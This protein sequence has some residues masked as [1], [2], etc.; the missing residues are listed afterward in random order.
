MIGAAFG[1][2][3][4][5]HCVCLQ[6][7]PVVI[8][9]ES[10]VGYFIR[11]GV[12][13]ARGSANACQAQSVEGVV[14]YLVRSFFEK[15][16]VFA[17]VV[18]ASVLTGSL[19]QTLAG[20]AQN[21][22]P[23][24]LFD[25]SVGFRAELVDMRF[26]ESVE[27]SERSIAVTDE[28]IDEYRMVIATI[29]IEKPADTELTL[30]CADITLHYYHGGTPDVSPCLGM[31]NFST[32]LET[33]REL[34]VRPA[35]SGPGFLKKTTLARASE[36]ATVFVDAI[37]GS[38]ESDTREAW[39]AIGQTDAV[40]PYISEGWLADDTTP[41]AVTSAIAVNSS[42][43]GTWSSTCQSANRS[44]RYAGYFTFSLNA[45][46]SVEITLESSED[47][48]LY[49]LR[50]SKPSRVV[51]DSDDDGGGGT[52]S[53][54]SADLEAGDYTIEATTY[55]EDTTGSFTVQLN[56]TPR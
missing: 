2:H 6:R 4:R 51:I 56:S 46:A 37:F 12:A 49:L 43:S 42:A 33:D 30:P 38:M 36:A 17:A 26:A 14:R 9:G 11:S 18:A 27:G 25:R 55:S 16:R 22:A 23:A 45:P 47:T 5:R 3:S 19:G 34:E 44:S 32:V 8:F 40:A 52:D 54:I 28:S 13:P 7:L 21:E 48:F 24:L 53:R 29:R 15:R 10:P 35:N 20:G 1:Y 50:G 41:C 31:S 39:I